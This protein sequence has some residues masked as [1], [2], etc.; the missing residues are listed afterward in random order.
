MGDEDKQ[1][2]EYHLHQV[3]VLVKNLKPAKHLYQA[4]LPRMHGYD[5]KDWATLVIQPA[6]PHD[7]LTPDDMALLNNLFQ[8]WDALP[9]LLALARIGAR[10]NEARVLSSSQAVR[11]TLDWILDDAQRGTGA[12]GT[13]G[14]DGDH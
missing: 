10:V 13:E 3:E 11:D 1:S 8:V 14:S 12:D 5:E 9:R 7:K 6:D 2:D 4:D